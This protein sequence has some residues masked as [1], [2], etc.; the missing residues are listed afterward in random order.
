MNKIYPANAEFLE[1]QAEEEKF[2]RNLKNVKFQKIETCE[3]ELFNIG[4]IEILDN[5]ISIP[6]AELLNIDITEQMKNTLEN[7]ATMVST[8]THT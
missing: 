8:N 5:D 6:I 4:S 2:F 1:V 7:I 3:P